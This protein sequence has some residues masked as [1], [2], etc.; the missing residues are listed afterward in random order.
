LKATASTRPV[1]WEYS[2]MF[3]LNSIRGYGINTQVSS[4]DMH[5]GTRYVV[6]SHCF[7]HAPRAARL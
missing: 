4:R 7:Q 2:Q 5:M 3:S 6:M 1:W